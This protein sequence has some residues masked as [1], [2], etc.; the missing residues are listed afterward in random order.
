MCSKFLVGLPDPHTL[1]GVGGGSNPMTESVRVAVVL[2]HV[3]C[4]VEVALGALQAL[5]GLGE[6]RTGRDDLS[7]RLV[8]RVDERGFVQGMGVALF[9]LAGVEEVREVVDDRR[10]DV[11]GDFTFEQ[12][13]EM[14]VSAETLG[15]DDPI[16]LLVE[17]EASVLPLDLPRVHFV[18][19]AVA[20]R[21]R[22]LVAH[23]E[24]RLA[25][26]VFRD[27][28]EEAD[29]TAVEILFDGREVLEVL[30]EGEVLEG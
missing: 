4:D 3:P 25:V 12:A 22:A 30:V 8:E 13:S 14:C 1:A 21:E 6:R 29:E 2:Q 19:D 10:H 18:P 28:D 17:T 24:E 16:G 11:V 26:F 9:V 20:G 15:V 23:D 27:V 5:L 7:T